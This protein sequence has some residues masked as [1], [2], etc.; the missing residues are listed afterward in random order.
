L[1]VLLD[2]PPEVIH[3][4]KPQLPISQLAEVRQAYADFRDAYD[5]KILDTSVSL[6][7]TVADFEQ[8][9][10]ERILAQIEKYAE[11]KN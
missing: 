11:S 9:Y 10:L 6:E 7:K 1:T 5:L 3:Q 8:H 2:A 4:R